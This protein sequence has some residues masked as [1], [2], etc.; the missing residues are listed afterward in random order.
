[1]TNS[2][3]IVA[4]S[5]FPLGQLALA[6]EVTGEE[7]EF[8]LG[9]RMFVTESD[10]PGSLPEIAKAAFKETKYPAV[11]GFAN[12]DPGYLGIVFCEKGKTDLTFVT[13]VDEAKADGFVAPKFKHH[14]MSAIG[15][16]ASWSKKAVLNSSYDA[17][18]A[19]AN[20]SG[21]PGAPGMDLL[22]TW[23][24]GLGIPGCADVD[25]YW[26]EIGDAAI[27]QRQAFWRPG[28]EVEINL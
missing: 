9:W 14:P 16:A 2:L 20:R 10:I 4:R 19:A 3:I 24:V 28:V 22:L 12:S 17:L 21:G 25:P 5:N 1:M 11:V 27:A 8:G 15:S 7:Y 26:N 13:G 18:K 6:A 23:L